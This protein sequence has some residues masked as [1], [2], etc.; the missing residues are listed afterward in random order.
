MFV[1]KWIYFCFL[2]QTEITARARCLNFSFPSRN[3]IENQNY[4]RFCVK[5][6]VAK[7]IRREC[8]ICASPRH[9]RIWL[10]HTFYL[11]DGPRIA[12]AS[13]AIIFFFLNRKKKQHSNK[14]K[15]WKKKL[16][17]HERTLTAIV[18]LFITD[19]KDFR[20]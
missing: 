10:L 1:R 20:I 18:K 7:I 14:T 12:L 11:T 2:L 15:R 3:K 16:Y 13:A 8:S 19:H 17:A 9:N 6:S 4:Y 5:T